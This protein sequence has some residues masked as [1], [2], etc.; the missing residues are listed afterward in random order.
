MVDKAGE[1]EDDWR[2]RGGELALAVVV[3]L[4]SLIALV[5]W[6]GVIAAVIIFLV[7]LIALVL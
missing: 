3:S 2:P 7:A 4:V 5:L 6:T 1:I